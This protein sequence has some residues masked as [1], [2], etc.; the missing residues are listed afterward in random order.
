VPLDDSDLKGRD[1]EALFRGAG[2]GA[3]R[4]GTPITDSERQKAAVMPITV[5]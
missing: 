2:G 3:E 4:R 5:E 1:Q